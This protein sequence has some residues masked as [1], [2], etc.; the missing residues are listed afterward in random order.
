MP[1]WLVSAFMMMWVS[2]PG[3]AQQDAF[4]VDLPI[5]CTIGADCFVQSL[6]DID[7]GSGRGDYQCSEATYDGHKGTDIRLRNIGALLKGVSVL[8]AAPGTVVRL[9][10][11]VADDLSIS[12]QYKSLSGKECGNGLIIDHGDGWESQYCHLR[13]GS[14]SVQEDDKVAVG[15][16]IGLVGMSGKTEFPHVHMTLRKDGRV[17]DPYSG[18]SPGDD[19]RSEKTPLWTESAADVLSEPMFQLVD[20]AFTDRPVKPVEVERLREDHWPLPVRNGPALVAYLRVINLEPTDRQS[21][22]ITGP[23][24]LVAEMPIDPQERFKARYVAYIG[25]KTPRGGW[26]RGMYE[27]TYKL[28]RDGRV[29][30]E[31]TISIEL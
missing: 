19:C 28:E 1:R 22:V 16:P 12:G 14:V 6:V 27:A 24:G 29:L 10:D 13:E 9:R 31:R 18:L 23:K 2:A 11:G 5:D 15:Q 20:F 8:A 4:Q 17:V 25:K 21:V 7:E 30:L 26:P 3:H